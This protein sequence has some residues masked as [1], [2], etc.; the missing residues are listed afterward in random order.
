MRNLGK[1]VPDLSKLEKMAKKWKAAGGPKTLDLTNTEIAFAD[2]SDKELKATAR[3]FKLMNNASLVNLSSHFALFAAKYWLPFFET[4]TKKTIFPQFCGGTTLLDSQ[5]SIDRLYGY[6]VKSLLDYGAEGKESEE[7]L[8]STMNENIRALEFAAQHD[9]VPVVVS[10]ISG[11]AS[12]DL[13]EKISRGHELT[14]EEKEDRKNVLKRVDSIC[15]NAARLGV[16]VFI[17][18]EE[19]WIQPEIDHIANT[20]MARYNK[21][22]V[23]VYNTFQ[24]YRTDRLAFLMNSFQKAQKEGYLLGAKLVRGAYMDK[25][26]ARAKEMGYPSPI[27]STKEATDHDFNL[28]LQFC[29]EYHE[30]IGLCC[31]SHNAE[32]TRLMATMIEKKKIAKDHP[33]L[34]FCQLYGMSD[35]LTFNLAKGGYNVAKYL[36]YG[37][38]SDVVPYLV[39]R[40]QENSSVTG[41][42]SRELGFIMKEV[43]RRGI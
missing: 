21:E 8:N 43:K 39:R 40:S 4:I 6:G 9:G 31:A 22:K 35:Y 5:K 24:L 32:S 11:I 7:D 38:V 23:V 41:D 1:P 10:K 18:A 19:S 42:M 14:A 15:H 36:V 3:L 12:N 30:K 2:K 17:D 34:M 28:A 33:H 29:L 13:L 20:M 27:Q 25:E 16:S 26:R 37:Q